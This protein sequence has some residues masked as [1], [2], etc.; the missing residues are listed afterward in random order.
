[1]DFVAV[2]VK[3]FVAFA[4]AG[5]RCGQR[6]RARI[7]HADVV[8]VVARDEGCG[9][10]RFDAARTGVMDVAVANAA[11]GDQPR[12]D[13]LAADVADFEFLHRAL[14]R[15]L[16]AERALEGVGAKSTGLQWRGGRLNRKPAQR[17][18]LHRLLR[19]AGDPDDAF[20]HGRDNLGLRH[21]LAGQRPI[22][23]AP[24]C[25][26]EMPLAGSRHALAR[27]EDRIFLYAECA[28][29]RLGRRGER[30]RMALRVVAGN[31]AERLVPHVIHADLG[32]L[33]FERRGNVLRV[34]EHRR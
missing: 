29:R 7:I 14:P 30:Q 1:M 17:D 12:H 27:V 16:K 2:E 23:D 20:H 8:D 10:V 31:A 28:R 25:A 3:T 15:P 26:V 24:R 18:L 6:D 34:V 33:R 22:H 4:P 11:V 21:I 13:A 32:I 5:G 9:A 19:I